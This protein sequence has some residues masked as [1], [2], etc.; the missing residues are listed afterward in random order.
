MGYL[1]SGDEMGGWGDGGMGGMS[2]GS[3]G[4]AEWEDAF[5]G[6]WLG[7]AAASHG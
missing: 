3:A 2:R 1:S 7:G 5:F 4:L 6:L